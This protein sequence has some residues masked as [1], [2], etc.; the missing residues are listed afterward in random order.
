MTVNGAAKRVSVPAAPD[1]NV[2]FTVVVIPLAVAVTVAVPVVVVLVNVTSAIPLPLVTTVAVAAP[3]SVPRVVA[4]STDTPGIGF[5]LESVR[6][7]RINEVLVPLA[8]ILV[9]VAVRVNPPVTVSRIGTSIAWER[10]PAV[11]VTKAIPS[12]VPAINDV[13][14]VPDK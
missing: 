13:V 5:P 14:T 4:K 7:A 11:A 3:F 12:T 8:T 9:G 2:T 6:V 10:L 1:V